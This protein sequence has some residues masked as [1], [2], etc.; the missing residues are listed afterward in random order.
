MNIFLEKLLFAFSFTYM[1]MHMHRYMY[2]YITEM[3]CPFKPK[4]VWETLIF[5]WTA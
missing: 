1:H 4:S 2:V 5:P 3:T